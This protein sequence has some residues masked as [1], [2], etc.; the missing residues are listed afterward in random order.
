M[1]T[2]ARISRRVPK[3]D[4]ITKTLMD[5]HWFTKILILTYRYQAYHDT[6]SQHLCDLIVPY[7]N[8]CNLRSNNI[9]LITSCHPRAYN[10]GAVMRF[11]K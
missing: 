9:M 11:Q 4:H 6:A 3:F 1:N 7:A 5:L 8:T 2:A 10:I